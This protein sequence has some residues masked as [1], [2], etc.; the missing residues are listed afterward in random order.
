MKLS[1]IQTFFE[2]QLEPSDH[3]QVLQEL[4]PVFDHPLSEELFHNIH[5]KFPFM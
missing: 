5:I 3:D 2:H 1:I 4:V